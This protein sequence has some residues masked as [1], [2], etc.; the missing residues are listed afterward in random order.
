MSYVVNPRRISLTVRCVVAGGLIATLAGCSDS[1]STSPDAHRASESSAQ[2]PEPAQFLT[3]PLHPREF[4][5]EEG[6]E[7]IGEAQEGHFIWRAPF[8]NGQPPGQT[9]GGLSA[10]GGSAGPATLA[11]INLAVGSDLN[12]SNASDS[13]QG[14]TGA[15]A[16][17]SVIVAGSNSIYPGNC[18]TL[19]CAVRAY[20]STDGE[21]WVSS[22]IPK[23]WQGTDFGITFDPALDTDT[24]GNFYYAF[25]GAPLSRSYPNSIAVSKSGPTGLGWSTPVAVTFNTNKFFDDKYYIAVDR[26]SSGFQNRIYVTWDRNTATNQILY[27]SYSSDRGATWSAPIK[28]DDGTSRFERV[29]DA[30]PAVNQSTGVVYDAWHNYAQDIIYVDKSSNGGVSWGTDVAAATTHTGFGMDIGCVG[31]R[32]QGPAHHLKVGPS[33][34][35]HLVYA[36]N[37]TSRG[38]DVLYT[39]STNG[40]ATW[41]A[42][43]ALNDDAGA[44]HQYHPTL[45]V[46]SGTDG[47]RV[48]V[49]FLDRRDD[50]SN[51][52]SYVYATASSDGGL[53]WAANKRVTTVAS[54]YDGNPNGPGDYSSST[55]S[56]LGVFPFAGDHRNSD[57]E[58]YT[59]VLQDS[60]R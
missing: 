16:N 6:S 43:V 40:G 10:G 21:T 32:S 7:G 44:A 35:L 14:E 13:Y 18:S 15:A 47:D 8:E 48:T 17:G 23:A 26:S 38:F 46:I 11:P 19:P 55:P 50:P 49:S 24:D 41:S 59:A 36:D 60:R 37:T 52:S 3:L 27:I 2:A 31:G 54:N 56:S 34:T 22:N 42:P 45:S 29:I 12:V 4:E 5:D 58:I 53:S 51:C 57:F 1:P 39:R 25:G 30:Y 20:T 9:R 33:G 28:V